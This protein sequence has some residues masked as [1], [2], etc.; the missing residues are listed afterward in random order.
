MFKLLLHIMQVTP[1]KNQKW[2]SLIRFEYSF[3]LVLNLALCAQYLLPRAKC[4]PIA[5]GQTRA[6]S[7]A[8]YKAL[9][10]KT[11]ICMSG[12]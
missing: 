8:P 12:F 11:R 7:T 2:L 10:Q 6:K 4:Q 3:Y 9:C 1:F 5:Q